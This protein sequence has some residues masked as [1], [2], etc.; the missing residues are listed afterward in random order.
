MNV[1]MGGWILYVSLLSVC[2]S[3]CMSSVCMYGICTLYAPVVRPN[4][5]N[6]KPQTLNLSC[7]LL[8]QRKGPRAFKGLTI[9][10]PTTIPIKG[11]EGV[12]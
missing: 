2:L 4:I 12:C 9:R 1:S 6:P 8:R 10:I 3:F 11:R 5:L 7:I